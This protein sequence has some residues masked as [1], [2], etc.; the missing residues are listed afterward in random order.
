[1]R[2]GPLNPGYCKSTPQTKTKTIAENR[3]R[4]APSS[5][6]VPYEGDDDGSIVPKGL[7]CGQTLQDDM[8]PKGITAPGY[9]DFSEDPED[10]ESLPA[11]D[12]D[13]SKPLVSKKG[14][15][16]YGLF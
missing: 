5:T 3:K 9:P 4:H 13:E 1:M 14:K 12:D 7:I 15:K 6:A 11:T 10:W 16:S 2:H 8:I